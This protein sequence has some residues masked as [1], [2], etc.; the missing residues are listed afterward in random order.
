M[1]QTFDVDP[2]VGKRHKHQREIVFHTR[3]SPLM[4][5]LGMSFLCLTLWVTKGGSLSMETYAVFLGYAAVSWLL[6]LIFFDTL[7]PY[8]NL[9]EFFLALDVPFFAVA[10][11]LGGSENG[12]LVLILIARII[13]QSHT[14]FLKVLAYAHWVTLCYVVVRFSQPFEG[15]MQIETAKILAIYLVGIYA[16]FTARLS[17]SLRA[18]SRKAVAQARTLIT[19]LDQRNRELGSL[20][21]NVGKL[22]GGI[23]DMA[24]SSKAQSQRHQQIHEERAA[25]AADVGRTADWI[26]DQAH[27]LAESV[28]GISE[29]ARHS[30][31]LVENGQRAL[32]EMEVTLAG[33]EK[34]SESTKSRF[35]HLAT[36]TIEISESMNAITDLAMRTELLAVNALIQAERATEAGR[37]FS[38]IAHEVKE[39]ADQSAQASTIIRT[40]VA[41]MMEAVELGTREMNSLTENISA[42]TAKTRDVGVHLSK[43]LV[44]FPRLA[45]KILG[46]ER[47]S[48]LQAEGA[49]EI[50]AQMATLSRDSEEASRL[51]QGSV[52]AIN[53]LAAS[54]VEV[55]KQV[56]GID[57]T[58]TQDV[59]EL[60]R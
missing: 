9:G 30:S 15:D 49:T 32:R 57:L 11:H 42:N 33:V 38:V 17:G 36:K 1:G 31:D 52:E 53:N 14:N 50:T 37:G 29:D 4:R 3:S 12:W 27:L 8:L 20:I 34:S 24:E 23:V 5:L 59:S 28:E 54:T 13:D 58:P 21:E 48:Q 41:D 10:V 19:R 45:K 40:I 47:T 46:M 44:F 6:L 18:R 39:L 26:S 51:L 60:I 35:A 43:V 56:S 7:R 2:E 25:A 16:T 55:D 22:S